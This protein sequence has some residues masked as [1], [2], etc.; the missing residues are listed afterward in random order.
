M[1]RSR[2]WSRPD[3]SNRR[4]GRTPQEQSGSGAPIADAQSTDLTLPVPKKR[5]ILRAGTSDGEHARER[6]AEQEEDRGFLEDPPGLTRPGQNRSSVPRGPGWRR[7]DRSS[8]L[9]QPFA[10]AAGTASRACRRPSTADRRRWRSRAPRP[11]RGAGAPRTCRSRSPDSQL[12]MSAQAIR[13][14]SISGRVLP[15][16]MITWSFSSRGQLIFLPLIRSTVNGR[17]TTSRSRR[18]RSRR[19]PGPRGRRR[20]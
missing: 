7:P 17:R 16:D 1:R 20:A 2:P 8:R 19:H 14:A 5:I 11:G 15:I 18:R 13:S 10:I 4:V 3:V 12:T 6:E 9:R